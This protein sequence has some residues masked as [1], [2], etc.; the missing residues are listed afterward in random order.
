V[1]VATVTSPPPHDCA[2]LTL[3][4]P[5]LSVRL[6]RF[7]GELVTDKSELLMQLSHPLGASEGPLRVQVQVHCA[8]FMFLGVIG[9]LLK[10]AL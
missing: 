10:K 6:L 8:D 9:D 3:L 4:S 2:K 7:A 1:C 5:S